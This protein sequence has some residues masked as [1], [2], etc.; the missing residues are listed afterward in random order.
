M[1]KRFRNRSGIFSYL[2]H[3]HVRPG[4]ALI[5]LVFTLAIMSWL[6]I[7]AFRV[8]AEQPASSSPVSSPGAQFTTGITHTVFLPI[9]LQPHNPL[10][11]V[12]DRAETG[13]YD[14]YGMSLEGNNVQRLTNWAIDS[15]AGFAHQFLPR[16]SPDGT[17]VAVQVEGVLYLMDPDESNIFPLVDDPM[18]KI[19]GVPK[20]S[21]DGKKI[22]YSV[23]Q[24]LIP[25]PDCSETTDTGSGL[26]VIDVQTQDVV[27][28]IDDL[29]LNASI[30]VHW[31]PDGLSL[32]AVK[33]DYGNY[34][35][36]VVSRLDDLTQTWILTDYFIQSI[37]VAPDGQQLAFTWYAA[38]T[39]DIDGS[40][41]QLIHNGSPNGAHS[42][43]WHPDSQH[44]AYEVLADIWNST[45]F[46]SDS[47]GSLTYE[48]TPYDRA[49]AKGV[50]GWVPDGTQFLYMSD[51][52]R[53]LRK[54]DIYVV[55][56]DGS[57]PV[58]LTA[59]S[60]G[61]DVASDYHP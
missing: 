13:K 46:V 38:Y 18:L 27:V 40:N 47:N 26:Q 22:A 9:T 14:I 59:G 57:N 4:R 48:L 54:Y 16:W 12:S 61:D 33:E 49:S 21:P 19:T 29:F 60:P 20:W 8:R 31:T 32:L 45:I 53:G 11:F 42:V 7:A 23:K 55:N 37:A 44:L 17:M 35:G 39:A 51:V 56:A 6:A 30:G 58:N 50:W 34:S 52:N 5:T 15:H 24:C 10:L 28:L 1:N 41:I 2:K 25:R 36:V 43:V 3:S